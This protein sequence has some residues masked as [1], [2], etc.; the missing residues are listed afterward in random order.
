MGFQRIISW[1]PRARLLRQVHK[2]LASTAS[3]LP[4][5]RTLLNGSGVIIVPADPVEAALTALAIRDFCA[6][7]D[8]PVRL[9]GPPGSLRWIPDAPGTAPIEIPETL[10]GEPFSQWLGYHRAHRADWG[11]LVSPHPTPLEEACLAWLGA[12]TRFAALGACHSKAANVLIQTGAEASLDSRTRRLLRV[13]QP[14]LPAL[15]ERPAT[16]SGPVLVEVPPNLSENGSKSKAWIRRIK[17]MANHHPILLAHSEALPSAIHDLARSYGPKIVLAHLS[18][19]HEAQE[20]ARRS[21]RWVGS[22]TPAAALAALEGCRV[23]I[24]G[25]SN[26]AEEF[27]HPERLT[28]SA[29]IDGLD[30]DM[31]V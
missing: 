27:P 19:A 3:T 10:G 12:G 2:A 6:R 13:L 7:L 24:V 5:A 30:L 9:A 28:I 31:A 22:R 21:G 18:S 29:K 23:H 4:R 1:W 14:N 15:Q 25:G 11:L 26:G 20:L 17:T 8:C 16:K